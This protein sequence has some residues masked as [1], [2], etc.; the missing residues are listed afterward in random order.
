MTSGDHEAL[1]VRDKPV[2]DGAEPSGNS[3]GVVNLLRLAELTQQADY[4]RRAEKCFA[5]F[6]EQLSQGPGGMS[7]MLSALEYYL[8]TP[9]EILIVKPDSNA[10]AEPL[11]S[12]LRSTYLPNRLLNVTAAGTELDERAELVPVLE[13]KRALRGKTTAFVCE[14]GRCELPTSDPA[15]FSR[16]IGKIRP[17]GTSHPLAPLPVREPGKQP[18]PW[19]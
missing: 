9:L 13:G 14:Q 17:L 3:V 19:E 7:K 8:D 2:H 5:A 6:S 18:K 1:L 11:L 4:R 15:V 10:E 12:R 16:Q